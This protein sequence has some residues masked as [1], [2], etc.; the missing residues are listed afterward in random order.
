MSFENGSS[1]K[2]VLVNMLNGYLLDFEMRQSL[3]TIGKNLTAIRS[4]RSFERVKVRGRRPMLRKGYR[5]A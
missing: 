3:Q 5:Y 4:G 1:V 2:D